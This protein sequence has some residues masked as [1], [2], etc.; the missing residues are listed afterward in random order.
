MANKSSRSSTS[1]ITLLV[2]I[3]AAVLVLMYCHK[4]VPPPRVYFGN[5]TEGQEVESPFTVQMQAENL[6]VEPAANGVI[7]GHGHF[8]I[9]IDSPLPP[10]GEVIPMDSLHHHYG[11]GQTEATLTLPPGDH[12][13]IL[14]FA[15]GDHIPYD[16]QVYQEVHIHVKAS[17][18]PDTT[19]AMSDTTKSSMNTRPLHRKHPAHK[20][21]D[22]MEMGSATVG[23][24]SSHHHIH[25]TSSDKITPPSA[26]TID[27]GSG[28][29]G[30]MGG[31][32]GGGGSH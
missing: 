24:T 30:G 11:K 31:G 3:I 25:D 18:L 6:V 22:D 16:P 32:A 28:G 13:L 27:L 7:K 21:M 9:V 10:T 19:P 2:V 15:S 1:L 5:L 17:V 29:A 12:T 23:A 20:A 4:K 14:Q 8:H 26:T